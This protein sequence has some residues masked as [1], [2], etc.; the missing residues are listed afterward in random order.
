M[1]DWGW[2]VGGNAREGQELPTATGLLVRGEPSSH[3]GQDLQAS[4]ALTAPNP[5]RK[6]WVSF[7][8]L[9]PPGSRTAR[10]SQHGETKGAQEDEAVRTVGS[11]G[12]EG[13][14]GR[15]QRREDSKGRSEAAAGRH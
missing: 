4:G 12:G 3:P 7:Q 15:G 14:T 11:P 6:A 10:G 2:G 1:K 13:L 5:K 8:D 9:G